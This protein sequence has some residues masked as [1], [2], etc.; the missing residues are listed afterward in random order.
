MLLKLLL[1]AIGGSIGICTLILLLDINIEIRAIRKDINDEINIVFFLFNHLIVFKITIPFINISSNYNIIFETI[2]YKKLYMSKHNVLQ[3]NKIKNK[4]NFDE[5]KIIIK[6]LHR[7][8]LKYKHVFIYISNKIILHE[9]EWETKLGFED[10][11][12]TAICAGIL[13]ILKSKILSEIKKRYELNNLYF[14]IIPFY[15]SKKFTM[16][17]N[18]IATIK[19]GYIIYAGVRVLL[20]NI[21]NGGVEYE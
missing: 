12:T 18:C 6:K 4:I 20:I 16:T 13:W 5:A 17:F 2:I 15:T 1:V 9:L 21:K 3:N 19:I 7:L 14:N 10:A 8:S 11:N